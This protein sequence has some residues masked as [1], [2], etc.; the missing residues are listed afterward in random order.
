M[1]QD[2]QAALDSVG[3]AQ[4]S[5]NPI[6]D[7]NAAKALQRI[8]QAEA[9]PL[10]KEQALGIAASA[11]G[12]LRQAVETLE[13]LCVGQQPLKPAPK[14]KVHLH[15]HPF[16]LTRLLRTTFVERCNI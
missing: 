4:I 12:D 5:C 8:A 6:T 14:M 9:M 3:V 11:A 1:L 2:I 7:N 16:L 15:A 10:S 13:L